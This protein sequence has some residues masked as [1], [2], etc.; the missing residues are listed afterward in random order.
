[1]A[2]NNTPANDETEIE[3]FDARDSAISLN[4]D[5]NLMATPDGMLYEASDIDIPRANIVQKISQID[6][7]IGSLVVDKQH[8]IVTAETPVNV[9]LLKIE[10]GWKEDVPFGEPCRVASTVA[11]RD[12]LLAESENGLV[13]WA[14]ISMLIPAPEGKDYDEAAFPFPL[15]GKDYCVAKVYAQKDG[16]RQ[17]FKRLALF[18]ATH[19]GVSPRSRLWTFESQIMSKGKYSWYAP[20]LSVCNSEQPDEEVLKFVS[21]F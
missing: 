21:S 4:G 1:M 6:G 19:P 20:S 12:V 5:H 13:E 18:A 7:P 15:A 14:D 11:E 17:T 10:K 16:Y 2:K 9:Y 3:V 8:V